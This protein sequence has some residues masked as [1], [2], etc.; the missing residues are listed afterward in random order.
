MHRDKKFAFKIYIRPH[1]MPFVLTVIQKAIKTTKEI[2][3][4][5]D[6]NKRTDLREY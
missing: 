1:I 4:L 6:C 3:H 2:S 5:V